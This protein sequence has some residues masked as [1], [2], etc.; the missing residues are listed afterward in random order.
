MCGPGHSDR[1]WEGIMKSTLYSLAHAFD[2]TARKRNFILVNTIALSVMLLFI[3]LSLVKGRAEADRIKTIRE[4]GVDASVVLDKTTV[5]Q[6]QR[7]KELN[8]V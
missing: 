2:R 8:Y 4:N 5:E 1:R 3:L 6:V 7:L